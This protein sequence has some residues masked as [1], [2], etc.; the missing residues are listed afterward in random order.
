M[1]HVVYR[2]IP[3]E[4]ILENSLPLIELESD[5]LLSIELYALVVLSQEHIAIT[6]AGN[7]VAGRRFNIQDKNRIILTR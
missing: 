6:H 5:D 2:G 3:D 7:G 4:L 1:V